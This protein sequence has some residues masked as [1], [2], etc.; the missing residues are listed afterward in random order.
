[1]AVS[2]PSISSSHKLSATITRWGRNVP[3]YIVIHY[4]SGFSQNSDSTAGM[5]AAYK[6][7]V[8]RG[9]NA[10]YLVGKSAIWE[11]V[12]PKTHFC[13]YSC[14]SRVGKKNACVVPGWGPD[15]YKG[16]LS[17]SH[18]GVAGHANT[19]NVEICSCKVGRKRCDPM[20]DGWYFNDETYF[21]AVKL[22]AWLCD[23][24]GIK[25]SNII[26][27]NQITG[28][29]CPAMWCNKAGAEAGFEAFKQNVAMILNEVEEDT[30][31]TS[32][33]P[34]P[35]GGVVNVAADSYFYSRPDVNAPIVGNAKETITLSYTVAKNGFYYTDSGWVQSA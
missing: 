12:N 32:P 13:T 35:E 30:P 14:G 26:M 11:M 2:K 21:N 20:D 8:E 16:P 24:F 9:S 4:T 33:S 23:E 5:L 10:H 29:L 15:T 22:V 25:V 7:Y 17:M 19:I 6:S 18:A 34:A 28:K 27:H 3:A 31:V 1:M